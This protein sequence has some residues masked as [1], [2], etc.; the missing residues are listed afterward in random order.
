MIV[1]DSDLI[2]RVLA[3]DDHYAF[4]QLVKKYQ[5]PVRRFLQRM[6][7]GKNEIADE[8]AQEVFTNAYRKLNTFQAQ[9]KFSTWLFAI[10]RNQFL[11]YVR[12]NKLEF[13]WDHVDSQELAEDAGEPTHHQTADTKL[14]LEGAMNHLRPIEKAVISLNYSQDLS[15]GDIADILEIPI[16]SVKTHLLR[17]KDKL[18]VAL[19]D[20]Q[21]KP[22]RTL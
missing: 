15:H 10:S 6:L 19:T 21:S 16:G 13:N 4:S 9:S 20:Y 5:S 11:Q 17:G 7:G 3:F 14:D 22:E 2:S 1:N 18:K 12:K 8:L